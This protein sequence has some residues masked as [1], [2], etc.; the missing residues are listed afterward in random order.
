MDFAF[1]KEQKM[2]RDSARD[3]LKSECPKTVISEL[4]ESDLGYSPK[5]WKKMAQLD[6]MSII[7]PEAFDGMGWGLVEL[8]VLF[9]E[10]GRAAMPGPMFSTVMGTLAILEWGTEAQKQGFLPEVASGRLILTLAMEEPD[11]I[12]DPRFVGVRASPDRDVYVINGTKLFVPYAHV[13]NYLVVVA[14]TAGAPGDEEGICV[15]VVDAKA[16]GIRL[17][18]VKTIAADKQFQVDFDNVSVSS[19]RVIGEAGQGISMVRAVLEKAT[20]IQCAEAAGGAQQELE[21]T[22][23]YTKERIQFDRPIGTFQAVQHRLAD[24][25]IDARAARWTTYQ[26]IWRLSE[27]LPA[28]RELAIAKAITGKACQ[29]VAFSAQQLHGGI[30]VDMDYDLHFYYRRA[31]AFELKFGS[32]SYHLE[33]LGAEI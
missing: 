12:Y 30:G 33:A 2:L 32:P 11:A 28:G 6:W 23:K 4:E 25:Y 3:F 27:G 9:E 20:A 16:P 8:A 26:A 1:S 18:P 21:M 29:R 15:F 17:T 31:K 13:A 5:L 7:I 14:R 19:D 10:F 24:M 22:A